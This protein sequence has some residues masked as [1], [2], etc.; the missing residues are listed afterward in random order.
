M[1][2]S[3]KDSSRKVDRNDQ[4]SVILAAPVDRAVCLF[5]AGNPVDRDF[6]QRIADRIRSF[7]SPQLIDV[8][9]LEQMDEAGA[10][11][12]EGFQ[13]IPVYVMS[14]ALLRPFQYRQK[15]VTATPSRNLPGRSVFYICHGVTTAEVRAQYPDME[16]LFLDVMVGEEADL[17]ELVVE[18]R[19]YIE[20]VSDQVGLW[21]RLRLL[22]TFLA[23]NVMYLTGIVAYYTYLAAFLSALWLLWSLLLTGGQRR[24][25]TAAACHVLY[26][27]GYGIN[28]VRPL[29]L[30][31]WLGPAWGIGKRPPGV[32]ADSG[33]TRDN[34]LD[35]IGPWQRTME[36]ARM[37][38]FCALCWL[39]IPGGAALVGSD[40][41]WAGG[42]AFVVGIAMPQLWSIALRSLTRWAYWALGMTNQEMERTARFVS[43]W[44]LKITTEAEYKHR[45][46]R[47]GSLIVHRPW[48]PKSLNVFISYARCDEERSPMAELLQQMISRMGVPCFLDRRRISG[49]FASWRT[50]V[51]NEILN[52][53]HFFVVLG[54][55]ARDAHM[56]HRE[57]RTALQRWNTE[58][59]PAVVCVVEPEVAAELE[60]KKLSPELQYLLHEAPKI[61]YAEAARRDILSRLMLQRRRQGL[62][63]DW[64]ALLWPSERL[65]RFL[66]IESVGVEDISL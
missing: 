27:T 21:A 9:E 51:V 5:H 46:T 28:R 66:E 32:H 15:L 25:E 63:Q 24:L 47:G 26:A 54:P 49:K 6:A 38:K 39:A 7:C 16:N 31:P 13:G 17:Q 29:D 4:S 1:N 22:A 44:G 50:H 40:W 35:A 20:H 57:I 42:A 53:T 10:L 14:P 65:R 45:G 23:T 58:L 33:R 8:D 62:W 37:L 34:F 30:W 55:N 43:L 64:R 18:L 48:L 41:A 60:A 61:T 11:R 56:M 12:P 3:V 59:E 52:C 36:T 19:D 2:S